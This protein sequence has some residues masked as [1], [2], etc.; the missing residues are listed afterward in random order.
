[1]TILPPDTDSVLQGE[2]TALVVHNRDASGIGETSSFGN[3][4]HYVSCKVFKAKSK[5]VE[6][7][8]TKAQ[9]PYKVVDNT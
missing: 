2:T 3:N 4:E 9:I 5:T 8:E 6:N 1:M 7:F